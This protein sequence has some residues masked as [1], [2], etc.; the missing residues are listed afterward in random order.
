MIHTLR[1]FAHKHDELPAFHAA[2]LVITVL[3]AALLNLGVF[4][5][6][7]VIHMTL[8]YVKYREYHN[9]S[10]R[11]TLHGMVR[12]SLFDIALLSLA[13]VIAIYLHHSVVGIAGLSGVLRAEVTIARGLGTLIPKFEILHRFFHVIFHIG[14][15]M[16]HVVVS[17]ESPWTHNE[18]IQWFL[19]AVSIV[20]LAL[21]PEILHIDL[22]SL[23]SILREELLPWNI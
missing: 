13:T 16:R 20:L 22:Q 1:T 15:H 11:K 14:H 2:Y 4:A 7:I 9:Y 5:L 19:V 3:V 8:D 6:L 10:L 18:K 21:A 17:V 12:E 23:Q